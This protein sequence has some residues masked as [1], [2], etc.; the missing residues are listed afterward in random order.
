MDNKEPEVLKDFKQTVV[1]AGA[2]AI[3][4]A[5]TPQMMSGPRGQCGSGGVGRRAEG[6][7]CPDVYFLGGQ[8]HHGQR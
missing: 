3:I 2:D 5:M 7:D 8:D 6:Q 1:E 4:N